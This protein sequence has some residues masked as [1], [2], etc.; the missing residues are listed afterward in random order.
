MEKG[1]VHVF[2]I[3]MIIVVFNVNFEKLSNRFVK[4]VMYHLTMG[5]YP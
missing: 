5:I 2:L 4:T 3:F 1:N